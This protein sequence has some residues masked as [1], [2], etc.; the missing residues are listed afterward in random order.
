MIAGV[1]W[2]CSMP[3]SMSRGTTTRWPRATPLEVL[4][5]AERCAALSGSDTDFMMIVIMAYTGIRWSEALGLLPGCLQAG[6]LRIDW[7]LYELES[8][9]YRGRPKD[10]SIRSVDIPPFLAALLGWYLA[11]YPPRVC[12]CGGS[13]P[14]WCPGSVKCS[15]APGGGI[16]GGLTTARGSSARPP[17]VGTQSA[18]NRIH[19]RPCPSLLT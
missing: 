6:Q 14:P 17:T 4:L 12:T 9:F 10:G 13:E 2:R 1:I 18:E 16:S 8:R 15:L 3:T 7:K 11:T 19:D 5:F